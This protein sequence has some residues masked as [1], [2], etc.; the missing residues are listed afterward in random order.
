MS[1][2]RPPHELRIGARADPAGPGPGR[3]FWP[4]ASRAARKP[5]SSIIMYC[6]PVREHSRLCFY[7]YFARITDGHVCN[8]VR[9]LVRVPRCRGRTT[10]WAVVVCTVRG[11]HCA[12]RPWS[13]Q[14]GRDS[15]P[16][17]LRRAQRE[18][19]DA[20]EARTRGR[21]AATARGAAATILQHQPARRSESQF[22]RTRTHRSLPR[23]AAV[24]SAFS[25][26]GRGARAG[27]GGCGQVGGA[28]RA[29]SPSAWELLAGARPMAW[30]WCAGYIIMRICA[31]CGGQQHGRRRRGGSEHE[32]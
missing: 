24:S 4:P 13:T 30:K 11:W 14:L 10:G 31:W 6:M 12:R 25:C 15:G 16:A 32:F 22:C 5:Q 2:P 19:R 28:D 26:A 21:S 1:C 8:T 29:V 18:K 23:I 20:T 17:R 27:C 3:F 9:V 7:I